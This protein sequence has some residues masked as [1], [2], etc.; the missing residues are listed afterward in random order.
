MQLNKGLEIQSKMTHIF[1]LKLPFKKYVTLIDKG[2]KEMQK[3]R[4]K[5]IKSIRIP[6]IFLVS[7][8][9][10]KVKKEGIWRVWVQKFNKKKADMSTK[11][12]KNLFKFK[13]I[14]VIIKNF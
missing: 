8:Q 4:S 5:L 14:K 1:N 7:W 12:D 10:K 6:K 11:I 13:V 3:C 2:W 9:K